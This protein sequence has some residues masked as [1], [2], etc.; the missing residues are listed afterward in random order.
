VNRY[1]ACFLAM[2]LPVSAL[3]AERTLLNV[4]YDPTREF[5]KDVNAAF[6]EHGANSTATP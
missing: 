2:L 3:G 1:T 4:S 5:Y 6:S